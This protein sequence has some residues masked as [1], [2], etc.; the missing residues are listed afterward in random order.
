MI[1]V[2][3][4]KMRFVTKL[5]THFNYQEGVVYY[6]NL[7]FWMSIS[8]GYNVRFKRLV[9]C[10]LHHATL[11]LNCSGAQKLKRKL[12]KITKLFAWQVRKVERY[13]S[14]NQ[15][16]QSKDRQHND[17]KEEDKMTNNDLQNIIQKAK[18]RATWNPLKTEWTKV[19]L[20][21]LL[22]FYLLYKKNCGFRYNFYSQG[23]HGEPNR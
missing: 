4:F 15:Y 11:F 3:L 8:T 7:C 23:T 2:V 16:R 12:R 1:V 13:Q 17:Q 20:F 22:F 9:S 5:C 21:L 18:Y 10:L 14:S 19:L 6:W